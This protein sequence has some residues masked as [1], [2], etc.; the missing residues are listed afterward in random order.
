[1]LGRAALAAAAIAIGG[2]AFAADPIEGLWRTNQYQNGDSGLIEIKPCGSVLC[3]ILVKTYKPTGQEFPSRNLGMQIISGTT[4]SGDGTYEGKIFAPGRNE[5]FN[6]KL[7]LSGDSL[8]VFG[9]ALGICR[10][11]GT[12]TRAE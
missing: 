4:A 9:C 11:G 12:W 1:M 2:P 6:S 5:T 7:E 8:A 10:S 3:G